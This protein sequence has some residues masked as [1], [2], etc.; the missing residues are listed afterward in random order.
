MVTAHMSFK[1]SLELAVVIKGN[2]TGVVERPVT[3][4]HEAI[5]GPELGSPET[6][7]FLQVSQ[8]VVQQAVS[9]RLAEAVDYICTSSP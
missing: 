1:I 9:A 5:V 7:T 6:I 4:E 3:E 8:P 2:C